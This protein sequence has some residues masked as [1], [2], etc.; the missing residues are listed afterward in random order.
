MKKQNAVSKR[1]P[2]QNILSIILGSAKQR[3]NGSNATS[4]T[5][6]T[7]KSSSSRTHSSAPRKSNKLIQTAVELTRRSKNSSRKQSS[8]RGATFLKGSRAFYRGPKGIEKV[9]V[10]GVHHDA[11]LEPYYTIK[12]RDGKEKQMDG[13]CLTP[14]EEKKESSSIKQQGVDEGKIKS[15]ASS[16]ELPTDQC[17]TSSSDAEDAEQD[18]DQGEEDEEDNRFHQGQDAYY[19]SPSGEHVTK[20]KILEKIPPNRY[21][22]ALNDGTKKQV[23]QKNL[24]GLI[25]LTSKELASLMKEKNE[26]SGA[27]SGGNWNHKDSSNS[28]RRNE[29]HDDGNLDCR[30]LEST[31]TTTLRSSVQSKGSL[32]T[33]D[34]GYEPE[35]DPS[36]SENSYEDNIANSPNSNNEEKDVLALPCAVEMVEAKTED[37]GTKVV[38]LYKTDME[39]YYR[40]PQG[41]TTALILSTHLDDL[42][43]P[44]YTIRLPDGREKQTDNAHISLEEPVVEEEEEDQGGA[45]C[46]EDDDWY[47][48]WKRTQLGLEENKET[49]V[50][51]Q[52]PSSEEPI[53]QEMNHA[54]EEKRSAHPKTEKPEP[55]PTLGALVPKQRGSESADESHQDKKQDPIETASIVQVPQ[56][57]VG[58]DVLYNSS[59]GDHLRA[60]I[61]KLRKDEKHRPYYVIKLSTGDEK[62]VYGHR[63]TAVRREE[64]TAERRRSR[65][66]SVTRREREPPEQISK[67]SASVDTRR[68]SRRPSIDSR[69]SR[70]ESV[71][72]LRSSQRPSNDRASRVT[73]RS[74]SVSRPPSEL[75]R[76]RGRRAESRDPRGRVHPTEE[77]E[78]RSRS[79]SIRAA[80]RDGSGKDSSELREHRPRE[81]SRS[82]APED[83]IRRR[84]TASRRGPM[85]P[86]VSHRVQHIGEDESISKKSRSS[87]RFSKLKSSLTGSVAKAKQRSFEHT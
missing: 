45:D 6:P 71:D 84:P 85:T 47:Q 14:I 12:F 73:E 26:R 77:K 23:D 19:R 61:T 8:K 37:G 54:I 79:K 28:E 5:A 42:L 50:E 58:D 35:M 72:R 56:F 83:T 38:P 29:G 82:R 87:S 20:I 65:S 4:N 17:S 59:K 63:L 48:E 81:R 1:R 64:R 10:V 80:P 25:D 3:S 36:S 66:K 7:S 51:T 13:K 18:N 70:D 24:A 30:R 57:R 67:R 46:E 49:P 22:I 69:A 76:S 27:V 60:T 2:R 52:A 86:S 34:Q 16:N 31:G 68:L 41:I 15:S 43:E 32:P 39:V 55:D 40:G 11:K 78:S 62:K 44:Y 75:D 33:V 9:T 74:R 21:C 53:A